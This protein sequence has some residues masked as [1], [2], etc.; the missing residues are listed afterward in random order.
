MATRYDANT[1]LAD[2]AGLGFRETAREVGEA[3]GLGLAAPGEAVAGND[4]AGKVA[5]GGTAVGEGDAVG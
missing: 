3:L 4:A 5:V 1:G 2:G